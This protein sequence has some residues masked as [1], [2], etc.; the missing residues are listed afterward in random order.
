MG[1][2]ILTNAK[3][4]SDKIIQ[5]ILSGA[6]KKHIG[7]D[8]SKAAVSYRSQNRKHKLDQDERT[9][10]SG[11]R[12][13]DRYSYNEEVSASEKNSKRETD[14]DTEEYRSKTVKATKYAKQRNNDNGGGKRFKEYGYIDN[15][16]RVYGDGSISEH[17]DEEKYTDD[18]ET[19]KDCVTDNLNLPGARI[20]ST[21]PN[22]D[23]PIGVL[24]DNIVRGI[25]D[26]L[27]VL[28]GSIIVSSRELLRKRRNDSQYCVADVVNAILR[29]NGV[30]YSKVRAFLSPKSL[31][32][33]LWYARYQND[34]ELW[35]FIDPVLYEEQC[36]QFSDNRV[37][38]TSGIV[39]LEKF[40]SDHFTFN[41]K[42]DLAM[43]NLGI[44]CDH[45]AQH[46]LDNIYTRQVIPGEKLHKNF[47][48]HGITLHSMLQLTD[49]YQNASTK[50][51][52]PIEANYPLFDPTTSSRS[53]TNNDSV[54]AYDTSPQGLRFLNINQLLQDSINNRQNANF[55]NL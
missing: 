31:Q 39:T 7:E 27:N 49:E 30:F 26:Y 16:I 34:R 24:E 38:I 19:D 18:E 9:R 1:Y 35:I 32:E 17:I 25:R 28:F 47:G 6:T 22:N 36:S 5:R 53:F 51:V 14:Q 15:R 21:L 20:T 37:V 33:P 44:M 11:D 10:I 40:N 52:Q 29:Y 54:L 13:V 4:M 8:N 3:I 12:D 48:K 23:E 2:E 45:L 43:Y 41:N 42:I 50:F 55:S 46:I